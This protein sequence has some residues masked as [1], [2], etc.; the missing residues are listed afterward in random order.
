MLPSASS[1]S[2]GSSTIVLMASSYHVIISLGKNLISSAAFLR[3]HSEVIS[4]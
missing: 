4:K 1:C 2:S 3:F